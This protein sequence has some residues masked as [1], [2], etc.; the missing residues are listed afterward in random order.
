MCSGVHDA[1]IEVIMKLKRPSCLLYLDFRVPF[2]S[3]HTTVMNKRYEQDIYEYLSFHINI[4]KWSF[5]IAYGIPSK[6]LR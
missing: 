3:I 6:E 4:F 2:F 1:G 5:D